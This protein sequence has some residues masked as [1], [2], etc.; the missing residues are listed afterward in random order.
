MKRLL[1]IL[2]ISIVFIGMV[3]SQ[4]FIG[5]TKKVV[6]SS[7][8]SMAISVDKPKPDGDTY[9]IKVTF[10]TNVNWYSFTKDDICFF[11]FIVQTYTAEKLDYYV[12]DYDN[13]F[14]RAL[15]EKELVWKEYKGDVFVYSWILINYNAGCMYTIYLTQSNYENNKYQYIQNFLK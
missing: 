8:K 15:N 4:S 5:E 1:L 6:L 9:Y 12:R 2:V 10:P 3:L 13:K 11:Y 7:V 14:L